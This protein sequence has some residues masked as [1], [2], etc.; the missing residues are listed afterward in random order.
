MSKD[1]YR[2]LCATETDI[3]VFSQDWWLD[4]VYGGDR[5]DVLLVEKNGRVAA[6][7]PLYMPLHGVVTMPPYTQSMGIWI[8]PLSDDTKYSSALEQRQSLCKQLIERLHARVFM[9]NFAYSFTDWLPFYWADYRQT[10]RYTYI[11]PDLSD[12]GALWEGMSQNTRRNIKR[13]QDE[14]HIS[15]RQDVGIDDFLRVQEQTFE[16][17]NI[18]NKQSVHVLRRLIEAAVSRGQGALF[19][20]YDPEGRLHA[21]AFV[22]WQPS[23]A[24]YIAG[25]GDPALRRSGAHSLVLWEAVRHASAYS[26]VFDFEGSMLP[27]VERFFREFGARQTPYFTI[28]KGQMSIIDRI[29][30]KLC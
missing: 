2:E 8:A 24:Y 11:L 10:T 3:P 13:A 4:A 20:G 1:R 27:G 19:G 18:R 9:Q 28:S 17:Q 25:G 7:W 29:R 16:R 23:S 5:W 26:K 12:L 6:A 14:A 22:V 30:M 15:V 21:A